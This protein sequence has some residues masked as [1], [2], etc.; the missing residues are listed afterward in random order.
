MRRLGRLVGAS[1]A[2][3]GSAAAALLTLLAVALMLPIVLIKEIYY[4][5]T[6]RI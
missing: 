1:L 2:L 4:R 5:L 6:N 3:V